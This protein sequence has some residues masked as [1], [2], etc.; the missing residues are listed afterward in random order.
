[1]PTLDLKFEV[2]EEGF[3]KKVYRNQII[4]GFHKNNEYF[5]VVELNDAINFVKICMDEFNKGERDVRYGRDLNKIKEEQNEEIK[6][7]E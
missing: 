6:K 3:L 4:L 1:M 7:G 5:T 2:Y